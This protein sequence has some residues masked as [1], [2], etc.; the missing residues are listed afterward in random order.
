MI[1]MNVGG[2]LE[3]KDTRAWIEAMATMPTAPKRG[4]LSNGIKWIKIAAL[5]VFV[6]FGHNA[7]A[8]V[9]ES[10]EFEISSI[11]QTTYDLQFVDESR[12]SYHYDYNPSQ[13]LDFPEFLA[14]EAVDHFTELILRVGHASSQL[15]VSF[16]DGYDVYF[17]G[18]FCGYAPCTSEHILG[19]TLGGA[20]EIKITN[21]SSDICLNTG[22]VEVVP[23]FNQNG[24]WDTWLQYLRDYGES[25]Q[26]VWGHWRYFKLNVYNCTIRGV[27]RSAIDVKNL[28]V[29]KIEGSNQ[30]VIDYDL[31]V[32]DGE[33]SDV[34][35]AFSFSG[36]EIPAKTFSGDIGSVLAGKNKRIIWNAGTDCPEADYSDVICTITA[37]K[38][39]G[40]RVKRVDSAPF[41]LKTSISKCRI[42]DVKSAYCN[43]RYGSPNGRLATFLEGVPCE[44][45]FEIVEER[46]PGRYIDC[47]E[48]E[49]G[50]VKSS[51][52]MHTLRINMADMRVGEHLTVTAVDNRG[53]RSRPFT[54]N[55]DI[56]EQPKYC[57]TPFHVAEYWK[58]RIVYKDEGGDTVSIFDGV[59][60]SFKIFDK[61]FP[62]ELLGGFAVGKAIDSSTGELTETANISVK[63]SE[64][65]NLLETS[66]WEF[67]RKI[68]TAGKLGGADIN[69]GVTHS[70]IHVWR[71]D[72]GL[73]VIKEQKLGFHFDCGVTPVKFRIP[74]TLKIVYVFIGFNMGVDILGDWESSGF[75]F[76]FGSDRF[77]T[78]T[79]G[80]GAGADGLLGVQGYVRGGIALTARG[81]EE[82]HI[83]RL[84]LVGS[85]GWKYTV[86]GMEK[87]GGEASLECPLIEGK[88][89]R[90]M[91]APLLA[92]VNNDF[93][94]ISRDYLNSR[95]RRMLASGAPATES[96]VETVIVKNGYPWPDPAVAAR[97][98]FRT[99]AY[100]VDDA[101]RNAINR[102]KLVCSVNDNS[103]EDVWDDATPDFKPSIGVAEDGTVIVAWMNGRNVM[104]DDASLEE[105]LA[106]AEI[107][108]GVRDPA[109]G[110]WI[111]HNLT[112]NGV[113]DRTPVVSV[114]RDGKACVMW[115]RNDASDVMGSTSSPNVIMASVYQNGTWTDPTPVCGR[116][117][118]ALSTVDMLYDG[119]DARFAFATISEDADEKEIVWKGDWRV[120]DPA[121]VGNFGTVALDGT[122]PFLFQPKD[123][124]PQLYWC[125]DGVLKGC[126]WEIANAADEGVK[127]YQCGK[128]NIS[129]S[130]K[131]VRGGNGQ[132]AAIW[133][134]PNAEVPYTI[135]LVVSYYDETRDSWSQPVALQDN[136]RME[137]NVAAAFDAQ[138]G[139]L[140]AYASV[141][142]EKCDDESL[143]YGETDLRMLTKAH[144]ID[145]A[146]YPEDL[147]VE[148]DG[149]FVAG[150]SVNLLAKV[151]NLGDVDAKSVPVRFYI[152]NK[153]G[154][155]LQSAYTTTVDVPAGGELVAAMPLTVKDWANLIVRVAADPDSTIADVERS[156]NW[157]ERAS[158]P[159]LRIEAARID[160]GLDDGVKR[161]TATVFNS[162]FCDAPPGT[163]VS[164]YREDGTLIGADTLGAIKSGP[165]GGCDAGVIWDVNGLTF[166]DA[167][168]I[169]VVLSPPEGAVAESNQWWSARIRIPQASTK[170]A[171]GEYADIIDGIE[172]RYSVDDGVVTVGGCSQSPLAVSPSTSGEILIPS[173][174]DG[175]P[176]VGIDNHAF[177]GCT[178]LTKVVIPDS[179]KRIG[180]SA[181]ANC[182][183]ICAIE[184]GKGIAEIGKDAFLGCNGIG[185]GIVI[186]DG[187]VL[188]INGDCPSQIVLPEGTRVIV[189]GIFRD[190]AD[191]RS[192][193]IPGSVENIC[194]GLFS[195]CI[196]LTEVVIENGVKNI[197]PYAFDGCR[198]LTSLTL[199]NSIEG[200]GAFAFRSCNALNVVEI[201]EDVT[202]V[203]DG[204]FYGCTGLT[205][206]ILP[207]SVTAIGNSS[208]FGCSCLESMTMPSTVAFV[209][210]SAFFGCSKLESV[211]MKNAEMVVGNEVFAGC[212][213]ITS[214]TIPAFTS[215][216]S[217]FPD[218][219]KSI[220]NVKIA[221]G[222][223]AIANNAFSGCGA[224]ISVTIP[225]SVAS[226][227]ATAFSG[228]GGLEEVSIPSCVTSMSSTFPSAYRVV[229]AVKIAEG[230]TSIA[231]SQFSGCQGLK[232]VTI[233]EGVTSIGVQAFK[234]CSCLTSIVIPKSVSNIGN[235]AFQG[236]NA[237]A[238]VYIS[239]LVKWCEMKFGSS[240][241]FYCEH[242]LYLNGTEVADLVIPNGT[243][244]ISRYAFSRCIGLNSV[245]IAN[246]VTNIG[247]YAFYDCSG[248]TAVTI[249]CFE[250]TIGN[251]AFDKCSA[252]SSVRIPASV[253]KM[254]NTFPSAYKTI[255]EVEIADGVQS[256]T[257]S[258]FSG[259]LGL[260]SV[261]IPSSVKSISARAFSG[262][263]S[264]QLMTIPDD[265]TSIGDYAFS[266]CTSLSKVVIPEGVSS[267]GD[268][269]FSNCSSLSDVLIPSRL[270]N[271]GKN[272]FYGC[273][274]MKSVVI[275][276]GL[277]SIADY[278]F[279][280]CSGLESVVILEGVRS[281][282]DY[283][284]YGCSG[285]SSM[286]VPESVTNIGK[287]AF[288][289]CSGLQ[290]VDGFV[291]IRDVV[292]GYFGDDVVIAVPNGVT[293]ICVEAFCGCSQLR[294][295]TMPN[296]VVEIGACAFLDC[297]ELLSVE[298]PS[299]VASIGARAFE[300]C[301]NLIECAV[302]ADNPY[303]FSYA[304]VL[305]DK[306]NKTL[307]CCPGG[308]EVVEMP[309]GVLSIGDRAF[310]NCSKL[311]A[312][313][314]PSSVT[315]LGMNSFYGCVG[316]GTMLIPNSVESIG[317]SA[318]CGC[319]TL[320][321]I[322]LGEGLSDIGSYAFYGCCELRSVT[323]PDSVT[324]LGDGAFRDCSMLTSVDLGKG[325]SAIGGS[326]FY[327]CNS[328]Q[329]MNIPNGVASIGVYAYNGCSALTTLVI[330]ASVT[331]I[332]YGAFNGCSGLSKVTIP[333]CVT[334]L[335]SIFSSAYN[336]VQ[337]VEIA[338]GVT[339]IASSEFYGC[340]GLKSVRI[341]SS[342]TSIG[343]SAF[344]GCNGLRTVY[345]DKDDAQR[346]Q[347]LLS[348][349]GVSVGDLEFIE[350]PQA[351]KVEVI[352]LAGAFGIGESQTI[353]KAGGV[354]LALEGRVFA[355]AGYMQTGW[356]LNS[357][358][359]TKD[360]ELNASYDEDSELTLYPYWTA[361]TYS[362]T[363]E[364]NGG[365]HNERPAS[366]TFD[367]AF[368]VRAPVKTGSV[369]RG[370]TVTS[371]LDESVAKWGAA[372]NPVTP[373]ADVTDICENGQRG[374]VYFKNL[375]ATE[376]GSVTLTANWLEVETFDV[377]FDLGDFGIRVG[378]GEL[379]QKVVSGFAAV[380]P[381]FAVAD[382]ASFKGWSEDFSCV[383][384]NML[385]TALYRLGEPPPGFTVA[386]E[387][388]VLV[389]KDL[390][391]RWQS[392]TPVPELSPA[393]SQMLGWCITVT[394]FG[395]RS[396][397]GAEWERV[398]EPLDC[399]L[400]F[401]SGG[402]SFDVSGIDLSVFKL[403]TVR[404]S[405]P[406]AV[407]WSPGLLVS[408]LPEAA[409]VVAADEW[410]DWYRE[411]TVEVGDAVRLEY[412]TAVLED[413]GVSV[414]DEISLVVV[415][416]NSGDEMEIATSVVPGSGCCN[417]QSET[418]GDYEIYLRVNGD[419]IGECFIRALHSERIDGYTWWYDLQGDKV[420]IQACVQDGEYTPAVTPEPLGKLSIPLNLGGK[421]VVSIG[422][423]SFLNCRTI[424]TVYI[425]KS[426]TS[427]GIAAFKECAALQVI[428][429][430]GGDTQRIKQLLTR[431]RFDVSKVAFDDPLAEC[432][433]RV[434]DYTWSYVVVD[435][436][437]VIRGSEV[438][439]EFMSLLKY[440]V[441]ISPLPAGDLTIP[442][443]LGG[444]SV[445]GIG[446]AAFACCTMGSVSIPEGV[447]SIADKA[448]AGTTITELTIPG[449]VRSI[450]GNIFWMGA[451][452]GSVH[453][454][455]DAP[456]ADGLYE[457]VMKVDGD[458][459]VPASDYLVTYVNR[460]TSGWNPAG[461]DALPDMWNGCRIAY[462]G[463]GPLVEGDDSALVTGDA[464]TGFVV[465]PSE[466]M[467][468][469]E[470]TIPQG[471]DAAKVT[472]EVSPKVV[473]VKPNGAK[474]RVVVGENDITDYL[475]IPECGGVLNIAAA[476]V[477][478]EIIKETLDPS[479]DAVIELNAANPRLTTAPTRKGLTYTLFEGRKLE[480]L[481]KG[482]SIIGNGDPWKPTITVSGGDAAFYSI[483][484]SK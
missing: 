223:T 344:Y 412:D 97:D 253:T 352:Y 49:S 180:Q 46:A 398:G 300:G 174:I 474:V 241:P 383:K 298:I 479:K 116:T 314:L 400:G 210:D 423:N 322:E 269:S 467:T 83:E 154:Y 129:G 67:L 419:E 128:D 286:M 183:G 444:Y 27:T 367:S 131:P 262:C 103:A 292:Y 481:S 448:F 151:H 259:C 466:G 457:M 456:D 152:S 477:K 435:G 181:F 192:V 254:S 242:R 30:V 362:I 219:Y 446:E 15:D 405:F 122:Q 409:A 260:V 178:L 226:I 222:V 372:S 118:G 138:G 28:S 334:M 75:S 89:A 229:Q 450:G 396:V 426:V 59:D 5:A 287:C 325:I 173:E 354:P 373:I 295:V 236:C 442:T 164:F 317:S 142:V 150:E 422:R 244:L 3:A 213:A 357:D 428:E 265:V 271:L 358:G 160:D 389:D 98:G 86:L 47:F 430:D 252:I 470:V 452:V 201:P 100:L 359:S 11:G 278:A 395:K 155:L 231:K 277:S 483:D 127:S 60:G 105:L 414:G 65:R 134:T 403:V 283:A 390:R 424:T 434:G 79:G 381:E 212:G 237:L 188:V 190:N 175:C 73:W 464:E 416:C 297:T 473:S 195:G 384:S 68:K 327:G 391:L 258:E 69:G 114:T 66:K 331:S 120:G 13:L 162:G 364:L 458:E 8:G 471:V 346:V 370:W 408:F 16:I 207:D 343:P 438:S 284:F 345:V 264:L 50:G 478:E 299:S 445:V 228:C 221:D 171:D 465:K 185:D 51:T 234:G 272:A 371:G 431:S 312:V 215:V 10:G 289:G 375:T 360:Y 106:D 167:E 235:Y 386:L 92:N 169:Q 119:M 308:L 14:E 194:A 361:N 166:N 72:L 328:L 45:E 379:E 191:L 333:S 26:I 225:N 104:D 199:P 18:A 401:N 410:V 353:T 12:H 351:D 111:C 407:V 482:D 211:V 256:I 463:G 112:D 161:L 206:V 337:A 305:Y 91:A 153:D 366:A 402:I 323:I 214:A 436:G 447:V 82:P 187:C 56:A 182:S 204:V 126:D 387:S 140:V 460:G 250:A 238:S 124:V 377:T 335:S 139:L 58:D 165:E 324:R 307:L 247:D 310:Y 32:Y 393:V 301:K 433:E 338:D 71:P 378:G 421:P 44:V 309:A 304:G 356:S 469:V 459:Y 156:N 350:A 81:P 117:F 168:S 145:L 141:A 77:V 4:L 245:I 84:G 266:G 411:V 70:P 449:S 257:D 170:K 263:S 216:S 316:L 318:F 209:G 249:S 275:P 108:V 90:L 227:A 31:V 232:A 303:Y 2:V 313:D 94:P 451:D 144:G 406:E 148:S 189:D 233:P 268:Y 280:G 115:V 197:G 123:G 203:S 243:R 95:P 293:N 218:A 217:V 198:A 54:V 285:I 43:G 291:V 196:G 427:I 36:G 374:N 176:V 20:E 159:L 25:E 397:E 480:S 38:N 1:N 193:K 273:S 382:W 339:G 29:K 17:N 172:W 413:F 63:K 330:P 157:A 321:S 220:R 462:W 64:D 101:S 40:K 240:D 34:T 230:A 274:S 369:F 87:A 125:D 432:K 251:Q 332:G 329:T 476:T 255:H 35:L 9:S 388:A 392:T 261:A 205:T 420:T 149:M 385:V 270:V 341:P 461:G 147:T 302:D 368:S 441:A 19:V 347:A 109:T 239:D 394:M 320:S 248:L 184:L 319:S 53:E 468:A 355:R 349:C 415:D 437:A 376:G 306:L 42:C 7:C 453:F 146:V 55:F 440:D 365:R 80:V 340:T 177:D 311:L 102:T 246:S 200:I 281:V 121:D 113:L 380:A 276:D 22:R 294:S 37:T 290:G 484:V 107:A 61:K 99:L 6:S 74:Q 455:G 186:V 443:R 135:D 429:V 48:V 454:E 224:L 399:T 143:S 202:S 78:V 425:P 52:I 404:F 363:Y 39:G 110:Q 85:V 472:V 163:T 282:G 279:Y 342:V 336:A 133:G 267:I 88:S 62:I 137:R 136:N 93:R 439:D 24:G 132:L 76:E 179:V 158:L 288:T 41:A 57:S 130:P 326:V 208:F 418:S 417:W 475:V 296:G 23:R 96:G 315:N 348:D 33:M 21:P